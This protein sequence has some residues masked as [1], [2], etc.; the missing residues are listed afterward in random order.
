MKLLK[1]Y[2]TNVVGETLAC[3]TI[4]EQRLHRS[5]LSSSMVQ[6]VVQTAAGRVKQRQCMSGG[7]GVLRPTGAQSPFPSAGFSKFTLFSHFQCKLQV[8][9]DASLADYIKIIYKIVLCLLLCA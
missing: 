5:T 4:G 1:Q 6:V 2:I 9:Q 3:T 8:L 7:G